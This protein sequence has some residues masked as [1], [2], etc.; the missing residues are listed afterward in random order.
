MPLQVSD[1]I[2]QVSNSPI[3]SFWVQL[4]SQTAPMAAIVVFM[5]PIP[6]ILRV[7]RERTVGDLP[8]L[9]YS[10]MISSAFVWIAYGIMKA[11]MKIWCTN[12]VGLVFGLSYF[13][14]FIKYCPP[15]SSTLPGSVL[16]HMQGTS[17]FILLCLVL[18]TWSGVQMVGNL[19]VILCVCMFAS[20]LA[21]L[22]VVLQTRSAR[23]IPLPFTL[24]S[25]LNC[26]LWSV[27]GLFDMHDYAIYVPN[28]LGLS[29]GLAQVAL[30]LIYGSG[31]GHS[32]S[33]DGMM[34]P[35]KSSLTV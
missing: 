30:K 7:I 19:G 35:L 22:K 28:L 33:S 24:A 25:I 10:S 2:T 8:L 32:S 14:V 27:A 5:A 34:L 4:C 21:A 9:P 12:V 1:L 11:E 23:A 29:F 16:Q 17:A 13:L 6:T 20:P 3:M 15:Q 26:F 18:S 31:G